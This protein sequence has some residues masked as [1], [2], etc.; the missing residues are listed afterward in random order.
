V[1]ALLLKADIVAGNAARQWLAGDSGKQWCV[2]V[3]FVESESQALRVRAISNFFESS[4]SHDLVESESS[5][6]YCRVTSNHWFA[7]S[8]QCW[9]TRNFTFFLR[10]IFAM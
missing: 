6:K 3:I 8:S 5:H 10:H 9:V 4:Q 2:R 7:S 1:A